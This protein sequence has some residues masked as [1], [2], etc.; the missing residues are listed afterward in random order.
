LYHGSKEHIFECRGSN[1]R[2]FGFFIISMKFPI[3]R[4]PTCLLF[5]IWDFGRIREWARCA[6]DHGNVALNFPR[7]K[8]F[9][10]RPYVKFEAK[11]PKLYL[12]RCIFL[13]KGPSQGRIPGLLGHRSKIPVRYIVLSLY[14]KFQPS[15]CINGEKV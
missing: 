14:S 10:T 1:S 3:D 9:Q 8:T 5:G 6:A 2:F 11:E 15:R 4:V 13:G 12:K 7:A